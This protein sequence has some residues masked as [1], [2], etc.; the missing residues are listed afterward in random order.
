MMSIRGKKLCTNMRYAKPHRRAVKMIC[1][2]L[3]WFS[4]SVMNKLPAHITFTEIS[5]RHCFKYIVNST[6]DS[7]IKR[8]GNT[9][10]FSFCVAVEDPSLCEV[11][12]Q[13]TIS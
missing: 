8:K 5:K 6:K 11:S 2:E 3:T 10:F 12:F 4:P 7:K 1:P 9:H 13:N